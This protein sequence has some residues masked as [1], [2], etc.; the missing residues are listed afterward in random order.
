MDR[1]P[2]GSE[3]EA[4]R[5]RRRT[6]DALRD[7]S[8][9]KQRYRVHKLYDAA[10]QEAFLRA[11][12][13][14]IRGIATG[15]QR[16]HRG[17]SSTPAPTW[18]SS[19]RSASAPTPST[20]RTRKSAASPSA[21]RRT[22]STT[23]SPTPRSCC[24]LRPSASFVAYD[25]YVREGRWV[26]EGAPPLTRGIAGLKVGIV[27]LGRIG[28]VIAEKLQV[29]PL[30]RRLFRPHERPDA[31]YPY[32][33]RSGGAGARQRRADRHRAGRRGDAGT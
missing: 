25:R 26:S 17:A 7:G 28:R 19:A 8:S 15:G 11:V 3:H 27:G 29:V 33:C 16:R 21:T 13:A 32:L 9:S 30:P 12:G 18:R 31:P 4:G 6:V 5:T 14:S 1:K 2:R 23:R 24:C 20:W 10:D 22:C